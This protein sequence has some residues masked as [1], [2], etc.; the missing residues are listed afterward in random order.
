M[1]EEQVRQVAG[2]QI[3]ATLQQLEALKG[4]NSSMVGLNKSILSI[5]SSFVSL[6]A[7][8]ASNF[9]IL[10][11]FQAAQS[12][13]S[14]ELRKTAANVGKFNFAMDTMGRTFQRL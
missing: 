1:S 8:I 11:G 7:S 2:L 6:E 10:I 4:L 12:K 5:S 9:Q 3:V 14:F 13:L